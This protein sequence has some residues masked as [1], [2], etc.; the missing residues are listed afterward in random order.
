[1]TG[2]ELI[3][4]IKALGEERPVCIAVLSKERGNIMFT[5]EEIID[6]SIN[7]PSIQLT[8]DHDS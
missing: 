7:G 3:K 6:L 4:Q 5:T 2:T 8:V 1:M